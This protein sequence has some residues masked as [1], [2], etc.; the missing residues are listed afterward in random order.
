MSEE[1]EPLT[2][3][4]LAATPCGFVE[5]ILGLS[6]Y[7]WQDDALAPL[8]DL[9]DDD[10]YPKRTK[11]SVVAPNGSGKSERI[12]AGA[13]LYWLSVHKRGRVVVTSCVGRQISDQIWPALMQHKA[14]FSP[15]WH[16]VTSP[17]HRISTP[18]GGRAILY[19]TND[20]GGVEGAH[21]D[22]NPWEGMYDG[23]LLVIV[24][25]A[26]SVSRPIFEALDRCTYNAQMLLSSPGRKEGVFYESQTEN[27]DRFVCVQ[28]GLL[29]CPHI[30]KSKID[31]LTAT[32]HEKNPQFLRSVLH[33]EFM[34]AEEEQVFDREGLAHLKRLIHN[35]TP[36]TIVNGRLDPIEGGQG[37]R[38]RQVQLVPCLPTDPS[39]WFRMWEKPI[40]GCRYIGVWDS[41]K[42]R[43]EH[44]TA[45]V[46][47]RQSLFILRDAYED[48]FG[49]PHK[50]ATVARVIP[51]CEYRIER[52]APLAF[53]M[54]LFY[55]GCT[56]VVEENNTGLAAI[57]LLKNLG[58]PIW[59]RREGT[60]AAP[61]FEDGFF[62][63]A[64]IR[65]LIVAEGVEAIYE[66]SWDIWCPHMLS[67]MQTFVKK[68][69]GKE[70]AEGS[71][72]DDDVMAWLIGRR[73]LSSGTIYREQAKQERA[74]RGQRAGATS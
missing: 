69:D 60:P 68:P 64:W 58:C 65:P 72:K 21:P 59:R 28:A 31:D 22:F 1:D 23:P 27:K 14:K 46:P 73:C 18:Y 3:V 9:I 38:I 57:A 67:E 15:D 17:V 4:E 50:P 52:V 25:E 16:W 10:G 13:I 30:P 39:R 41:S 54:S 5:L 70:E 42:G 8:D 63:H 7:E 6:L 66:K 12:V 11:V 34:D 35:I 36:N 20:A 61:R 47:D 2:P 40:S 62:T 49:F 33:G 74:G 44:I 53:Y 29:D 56:F 32:Y 43:K 48:A 24:D 26:K 55:G 71:L 37:N 19:T 45:R 51:P